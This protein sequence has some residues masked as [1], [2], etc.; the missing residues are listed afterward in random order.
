MCVTVSGLW[1]T[2][3]AV[4]SGSGHTPDILQFDIH[5]NWSF[6]A[7]AWKKSHL[8]DWLI[9]EGQRRDWWNPGDQIWLASIVERP[10]RWCEWTGQQRA[11]TTQQTT[12]Q[13]AQTA[14]THKFL[15]PISSGFMVNI[16]DLWWRVIGRMWAVY[17]VRYLVQWPRHHQSQDSIP[18]HPD[19]L[20]S[21]HQLVNSSMR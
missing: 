19:H 10:E 8:N 6:G 11:T 9:R 7:C 21:Y 15:G 12:Q 3:S 16:W 13:T 4:F 18:T 17:C 14:S 5:Y 20:R 1:S 2:I